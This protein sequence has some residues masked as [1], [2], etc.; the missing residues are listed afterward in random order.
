MKTPISIK[1]IFRI[2]TVPFV[3]AL[4]IIAMLHQCFKMAIFYIRFG[5]EFITYDKNETILIKDVYEAVRDKH[6][7]KNTSTQ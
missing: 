5:G 7:N 6:L 4:Y 1:I 3:I 2:I